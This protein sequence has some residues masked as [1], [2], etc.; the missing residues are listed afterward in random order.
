MS[1]N[2]PKHTQMDTSKRSASK[3]FFLQP[4]SARQV[5]QQ[6]QSSEEWAPVNRPNEQQLSYTVADYQFV[7]QQ[8]KQEFPTSASG[9]LHQMTMA[10]IS[11]IKANQ[12]EEKREQDK[13][14]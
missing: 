10:R 6:R 5:K 8:L 1:H 12:V 11:E 4:V 7:F 3:P 2:V 14:E 9:A 13:K